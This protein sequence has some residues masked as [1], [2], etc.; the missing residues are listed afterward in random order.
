MEKD[1]A[2]KSGRNKD[3]VVVYICPTSSPGGVCGMDDLRRTQSLGCLVETVTMRCRNRELMERDR[4]RGIFRCSSFRALGSQ[5]SLDLGARLGRGT[6]AEGGATGGGGFSCSVNNLD[7]DCVSPRV[8]TNSLASQMDNTDAAT[9]SEYADLV[10]GLLSTTAATDLQRRVQLSEEQPVYVRGGVRFLQGSSSPSARL[11]A[12]SPRQLIV[13][14]GVGGGV[15]DGMPVSRS[16]SCPSVAHHVRRHP[17]VSTGGQL[18]SGDSVD[19]CRDAPLQNVQHLQQQQQG[20]VDFGSRFLQIGSMESDSFNVTTPTEESVD[21]VSPHYTDEGDFRA[22]ADRFLAAVEKQVVLRETD[23]GTGAIDQG[24]N[25]SKTSGGQPVGNAGVGGEGG[26]GG[27]LQQ[28]NSK[29]DS[30][31]RDSQKASSRLSR[32]LART[33]CLQW[34][35]SLDEGD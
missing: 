23:G 2:V 18:V 21:R 16:T 5:L 6:A 13:G 22:E 12:L 14:E 10:T 28:K 17:L 19:R 34:L 3:C 27:T 11:Q 7:T 1:S 31:V 24:N 8:S 25:E 9:A 32:N 26:G 4:C 30:V 33:K 29:V 35:N 15:G 20:R